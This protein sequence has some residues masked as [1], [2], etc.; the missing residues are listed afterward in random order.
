MIIA[1]NSPSWL[2]QKDNTSINGYISE[3]PLMTFRTDS[4]DLGFN[5]IIHAR[6]NTSWYPFTGV[7]VTAA[8]RLQLFTG[9][10]LQNLVL[11]GPALPLLGKDIG[12]AD[13]TGV[14]PSA[15]YGNID[16]AFV[17]LS[18]S[19]FV[20]IMGRQRVNWSTNLIWNPNDWFNAYNYFDFDYVERPGIDGL[21]AVYYLGPT[22]AVELALKASHD[23]D[24]RTYAAMYH[25][26]LGGFDYQFQGGMFGRDAALGFSWAGDILSGG[27]RGEG[28]GYLPVLNKNGSFDVRDSTIFVAALSGDYTFTNRIYVLFEAIYNGFGSNGTLNQAAFNM[29]NISAKNLTPATYLI[30]GSISYPF[31]SLTNAIFAVMHPPGE[32]SFFLGPSVTVSLF[33]NVELLV[34]GQIFWGSKG[35]LFGQTGNIFGGRLRYSF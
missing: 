3:L 7:T 30:Y 19:S 28:S 2:P 9:S 31:T 12:Y 33:Q 27:F 17:S 4:L 35:S 6:L 32:N 20:I 15:L 25:M 26:N 8:G 5:N 1:Q 34:L 21:R 29:R 18:K 14:W 16:R 11:P 10:N 13:I 23:L 24:R 22:S